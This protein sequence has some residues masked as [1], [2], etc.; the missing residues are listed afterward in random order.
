MSKHV[1]APA[2]AVDVREL[3]QQPGAH[4]HVVLRAALPDLA[5]P[6]ASVPAGSP[7]SVDAE[8]E[9]VVEGLLVTGKVGA[10]VTL[11][12]VRCLRDVDDELEAEVRELFA[13]RGSRSAGAEPRDDEDEGYA[14]LPDDRLPLDTMVRDTLVLAFPSFPLCRP[15]CAG[16]CPECGADRNSNDCGHGGSGAT[17][18]RWAALAG[19]RRDAEPEGSGPNGGAPM[20]KEEDVARPEA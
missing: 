8:V 9:S 7:V 19:L 2:L 15:D 18:P 20:I 6:V 11:R 1:T 13:A 3:L 10:T 14:V 5:T 16:L 12:C 17:D 4:K